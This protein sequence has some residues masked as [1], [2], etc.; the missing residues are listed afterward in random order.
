M[1]YFIVADV[2]GFYNEMITA[3]EE[4]GFDKTNYEHIFVSLGDYFDRGKQ[5]KE[6]LDFVNS[7]PT[8][9]KI[10]IVGNHDL[11]MDEMIYRGYPVSSDIYNGTLGTIHQIVGT[12]RN[13]GEEIDAI[14]G[15]YQYNLYR[16]ELILWT[17][18]GDNIFVHGWIPQID[19]KNASYK[20]W[21]DAT[22]LNGMARWSQGIKVPNKTIWCGHWHTS[23]GHA[24]LHHEGVEF[25]NKEYDYKAFGI[26]PIVHH[27][28][29]KDEGIVA[30]DACTALSH[31]VNCEVIEI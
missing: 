31:K 20:D 13:Q 24:H 18:V 2:H 19:Y 14:R 21:K 10:L 12:R 11:L 3:L 28:P 22:W 9:R 15:N 5:A 30:M 4:K 16:K 8:E 25:I 27:E 6:C 23:W 26:T 1:K 29:F 17:E 7:L